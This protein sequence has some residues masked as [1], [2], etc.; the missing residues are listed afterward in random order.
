[1]AA[2]NAPADAGFVDVELSRPMDID[3]AKITKLRMREPTVAD[4]L[5][6]EEFKGGEA[7]KEIAMLANLC[8][9]APDDIKRLT[10]KDY[11][12]LQA[13]FLGFIG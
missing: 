6:S 7:A 10:L 4:Q 2:K 12:R 11:K 1:M 3:G 9:I 13:A 5:A 8:E